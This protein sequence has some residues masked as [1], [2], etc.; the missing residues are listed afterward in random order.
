MLTGALLTRARP[1]PGG[2]RNRRLAMESAGILAIASRLSTLL[3]RRDPLARRV[4]LS[5]AGFLWCCLLGVLAAAFG[6]RSG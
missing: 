3:R 5:K 4:E 6:A 1:M 2:V